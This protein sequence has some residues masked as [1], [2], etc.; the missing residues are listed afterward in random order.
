MD[1]QDLWQEHK[2]WILGVVAGLVVYL[3]GAKIVGTFF[4]SH[5]AILR[6][7]QLRR[8]IE[9]DERFDRA[10]LTKIQAAKA[11]IEAQEAKVRDAVA[12]VPGERFLLKGN[13]DPDTY[14]PEVAQGV[15]TDVLGRARE[16]SVELADRDLTW[17]APVGRE[18][19]ERTLLGLCVLQ[20]AATRL[21]EAGDAVRRADPEALGLVSIDKLAIEKRS[22]SA[23]HR[24][25]RRRPTDQPD[26][27]EKLDEIQ[28]AFAFRCD[29]ATLQTF[30]EQLRGRQPRIGLAPDL[31]VQAGDQI[32]DPLVVRGHFSALRILDANS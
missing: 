23:F 18:E 15:R 27:A 6:V 10:D 2:R 29:V 20:N 24:P 32:G 13:G 4:Y 14:F 1:L 17:P 8:S 25:V 5:G 9:G 11:E 30:L 7:N 21:L 3:V 19:I 31:K 16:L 12:F 22:G 26:V 28:V